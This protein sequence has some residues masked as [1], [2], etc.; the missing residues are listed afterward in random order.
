MQSGTLATTDS[1]IIQHGAQGQIV[2]YEFADGRVLA[3][4]EALSRQGGTRLLGTGGNDRITGTTQ[5]DDPRGYG[6]NDTLQKHDGTDVPDGGAG[7][8]FWMGGAWRRLSRAA[9]RAQMLQEASWMA[10][11]GNTLML[12]GVIGWNDAKTWYKWLNGSALGKERKCLL[13]NSSHTLL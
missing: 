1:V 12:F 3:H 13:E 5:A 11:L 4:E 7:R 2:R 6:D 8:M 10:V 9:L